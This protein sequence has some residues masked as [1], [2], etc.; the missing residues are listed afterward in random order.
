MAFPA[1]PAAGG[2]PT[3]QS[4][5]RIA[6]SWV[7]GPMRPDRRLP[8]GAERYALTPVYTAHSVPAKLR[9]SH[10]TKKGT[11]GRLCVVA[12]TVQFSLQGQPK[13]LATVGP[14]ETLVILPAEPHFIEIS[15]AAEFYIEFWR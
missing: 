3:R 12:G 10:T 5:E 7:A 8:E 13:P 9:S 11:Y 15:D 2:Q 1:N 4:V 6:A 14:G